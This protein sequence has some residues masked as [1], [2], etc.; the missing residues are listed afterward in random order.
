MLVCRELKEF[1]VG[2]DAW[3]GSLYGWGYWVI[4]YSVGISVFLAFV[5][6]PGGGV[7]NIL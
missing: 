6:Y 5:I 3:F 4:S 1:G 2:F 7:L